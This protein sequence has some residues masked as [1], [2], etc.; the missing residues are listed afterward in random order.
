MMTPKRIRIVLTVLAGLAVALPATADTRFRV[1]RMTRGD[2]PFGKGQCDIRLRI[3]REAEVTVR[4]DMVYVRTISGREA[5][6]AGSECNEPLPVRVQGF[7]FDVKDGRGQVR[8]I[9]EPSPRNNGTAIVRIRDREGGDGRYHFRLSWRITGRN[10]RPG[11]IG[12]PGGLDRPGGFD[13][14][15]SEVGGPGWNR[16]LHFTGRGDGVYSHGRFGRERIYNVVVRIEPDR[17]VTVNF[18]RGRGG[19]LVFRGRVLRFT[20]DEITADVAGGDGGALRG[21]M[22]IRLGRNDRVS[23]IEM[24]GRSGREQFE[25]RWRD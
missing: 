23:S 5:R 13:R 4:G 12:R 15:G 11:V 9:A 14:P 22:R 24:G 3:D 7:E 6:D 20:D 2:V 16:R 8:L 18:E 1:Q 10:D 21:M 17:D 25:V 19:R